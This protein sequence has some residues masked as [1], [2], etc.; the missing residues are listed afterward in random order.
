[1]SPHALVSDVLTA[2]ATSA[3]A[4]ALV[5]RLLR[6]GRGI[7]AEILADREV[8]V[9]IPRLVFATAGCGAA[10]GLALGLPGGVAACIATAIKFPLVLLGSAAIGLPALRLATA[11]SGLRLRTA[12]VSALLLQAL[13]TAGATM[14]ALA[15]LAVVGWLTAST[16]GA[17][18]WYA[19]RRAVAAFTVVAMLGGLVGASRLLRALPVL[20]VGPWAGLFGAAGMQLGW[21]LRPVVGQPEQAFALLR[22]LMSN[23]LA[24][25]LVLLGTVLG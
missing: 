17:G 24:E 23:G 11:L 5:G 12:Q 3:P 15:P 22:P 10:F 20:A 25:V 2:P 8:E 6:D 19:Y 9:L 4:E 18:D 1:M 21:L 16:W 13:A 7:T 14:A